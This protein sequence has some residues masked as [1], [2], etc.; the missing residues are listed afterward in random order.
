MSAIDRVR[1]DVPGHPYDVVVGPGALGEIGGLLAGRRRVAVVGRTERAAA[2][3]ATVAA[4]IG[5]GTGGAEVALVPMAAGEAVKTL[6]TVEELCRAFAGA[7][8][9]R[10]DAVVA[11]GGGVVGDTAGFAAASYHR[12]VD[13]V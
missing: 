4:V 2:H 3:A 6:A 10:D 7:G 11:V 12:G 1:V 13:L 9:L 5:G 8:L